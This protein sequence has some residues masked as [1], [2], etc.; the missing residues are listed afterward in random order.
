M[1]AFAYSAYTEGGKR[2]RGT[3]VAETEAQASAQLQEQ[4]LYVSTLSARAA[5]PRTAPSGGWRAVWQRPQRLNADLQAVLTRQ[6]AVLL[7]AGLSVEELLDAIRASG[8]GPAVDGAAARAKV[9]L[10]EGSPFSEALAV[11][12]AGFPPYFTAAVAAGERAGSLTEVFEALADHLEA[13]GSE[14]AQI[15][16]ALVYPAFVALVSLLVCAIL[17]VNVTPEIAAI[18]EMSGQPLPPLTQTVMAA[19]DAVQAAPWA[20][21]GGFLALVALWLAFARLPQ[22]RA[23]RDRLFMRLPLSGRLMRQAAAVQYLRTLALVLTSR[24][25]VPAATAAAAGVLD[26]RQFRLE[27][28]A[29]CAAVDRGEKLSDALCGLTCLPQIA[30]QLIGAGEASSRLALMSERSAVLAENAMANDRKRIAAL[31]EPALTLI[32][33]GFVL[34]IVLAVLLPIFDLQSMVTS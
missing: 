14:K 21:V 23:V 12:G 11:S 9:A 1:K 22:L 7:G 29:V 34:V 25:A 6:I 20:F 32:V 5:P 28:D 18:F 30:L 19:G 4:G 13:R 15:A 27:A 10:L 2:R 16:T 8:S 26:L 24:N 31:L 17:L 33:G 3:V